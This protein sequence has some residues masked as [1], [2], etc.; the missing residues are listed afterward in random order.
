MLKKQFTNLHIEFGKWNTSCEERKP[1][2]QNLPLKLCACKKGL[3]W[4][5]FSHDPLRPHASLGN[6]ATACIVSKRVRHWSQIHSGEERLIVVWSWDSAPN[7]TFAKHGFE[8]KGKW[9]KYI[10]M[11]MQTL[12]KPNTCS[13]SKATPPELPQLTPIMWDS[14]LQGKEQ[15]WS[16]SHCLFSGSAGFAAAS[17]LHENRTKLWIAVL[18]H[19]FSLS[20]GPGQ[21]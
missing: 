2:V 10:K 19:T 9:Q 12:C 15:Q 13:L 21:A 1:R 7:K 6:A 20:C 11:L 17:F 8:K 18:E 16:H 3:C 14:W 5:P 4:E